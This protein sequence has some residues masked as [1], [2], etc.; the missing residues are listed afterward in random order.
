MSLQTRDMSLH[1]DLNEAWQ[2]HEQLEVGK[3]IPKY[4]V[5]TYTWAYLTP[6]AIKT[7]DHS[8]V[9]NLILFGNE[10][11][12]VKMVTHEVEALPKGAKVLQAST[13]YSKFSLCL[14]DAIGP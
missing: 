2:K 14:G 8:W 5:D 12:L 11:S 3:D 9:V 4:L 7:F 10:K 13:V 1:K 6:K